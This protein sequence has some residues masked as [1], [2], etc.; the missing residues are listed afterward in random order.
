MKIHKI[1]YVKLSWLQMRIPHIIIATNTT[2]KE[3]GVVDDIRCN[4][5]NNE[6]ASIIEHVFWKCNCIRLFWIFF[7]RSSIGGVAYVTVFNLSATWAAAFRLRGYKCMLV[8][9]VFHNP[10]NSDIDYRMF[11]VRTW[12]FVCVRIHTGAR[13][14]DSESAQPF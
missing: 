8:I 3:I 1:R 14:T 9:V 11:N 4:F 7:L 12:Y 2:L 6:R 5:C 13:H 10:P